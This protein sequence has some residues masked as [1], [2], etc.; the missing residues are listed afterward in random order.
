MRAGDGAL[1]GVLDGA[2]AHHS[3]PTLRDYGLIDEIDNPAGFPGLRYYR[4]SE[5]GRAFA[6]QVRAGC[7]QLS[8]MHRLIVRLVG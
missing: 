3:Y 5:R 8:A 6:D 4:I 7:Q 2:I 1:S